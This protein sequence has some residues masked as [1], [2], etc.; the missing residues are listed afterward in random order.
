MKTRITL[1][2]TKKKLSNA[3]RNTNQREVDEEDET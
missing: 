2:Q 3:H 1:K